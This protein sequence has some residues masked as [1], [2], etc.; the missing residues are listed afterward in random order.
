MPSDFSFRLS[1][2]EIPSIRDKRLPGPFL[3]WVS[4]GKFWKT[5]KIFNPSIEVLSVEIPGTLAGRV[6]FERN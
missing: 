2:S 4:R 5:A 1:G 6:D 3:E